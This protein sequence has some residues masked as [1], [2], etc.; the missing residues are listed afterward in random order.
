MM[1]LMLVCMFKT[2]GFSLVAC[3]FS[4]KEFY[5]LLSGTISSRSSVTMQQIEEKTKTAHA[6][7]C[8]RYREKNAE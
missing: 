6:D 8:K 4:K 1:L 2:S 7:R 3:T 5:S